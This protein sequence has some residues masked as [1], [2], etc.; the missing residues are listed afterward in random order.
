MAGNTEVLGLGRRAQSCG[1]RGFSPGPCPPASPR[2]S[3]RH[4]RPESAPARRESGSGGGRV[5]GPLRPAGGS[6]SAWMAAPPNTS[7]SVPLAL[8]KGPFGRWGSDP[9]CQGLPGRAERQVRDPSTP[10]RSHLLGQS[11]WKTRMPAGP[12]RPDGSLQEF[13][14]LEVHWDHL[15]TVG[16]TRT[17]GA[18]PRAGASE[19]LGLRPRH[20]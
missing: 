2:I 15:G 5:A 6:R 14:T 8:R 16:A 18:L 4:L 7:R 20:Q 9:G 19:P 13:P 1:S 17:P 10:S 3:A 11:C 12:W